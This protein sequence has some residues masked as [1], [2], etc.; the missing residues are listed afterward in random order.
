MRIIQEKSKCI[1]CGACA[2]LC[3][4]Y[5]EMQDDGK[6]H[7]IGSNLIDKESE[8]YEKIIEEQSCAKEAAEGCPVQ[9]IEIKN[10]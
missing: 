2:S 7:I 9:C 5:F 8:K 10:K 1:G 6:A 3:A 4:K